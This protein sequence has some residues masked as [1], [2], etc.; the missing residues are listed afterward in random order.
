MKNNYCDSVKYILA[1]NVRSN[2]NSIIHSIIHRWISML[3][4]GICSATAGVAALW[5]DGGR[6]YENRQMA[7]W[8]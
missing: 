7:V 1:K 8:I 4:A 6:G 2:G 5:V 3:L